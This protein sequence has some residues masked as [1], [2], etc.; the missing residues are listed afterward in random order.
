MLQVK[1]P[2]FCYEVSWKV[3]LKEGLV[4]KGVMQL[5]VGHA[6]ALKPAVKDLLNTAQI[7]L[8][9]LAGDGDVVN[10]VPVQIC[11][12]QVTARLRGKHWCL[13]RSY[14]CRS[15]ENYTKITPR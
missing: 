3:A 12:L 1:R 9:L 5:A 7:S 10:E 8:A 11:H 14:A 6:S 4:L 13:C 2:T 15:Q